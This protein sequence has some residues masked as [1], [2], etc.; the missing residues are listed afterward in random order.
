MKILEASRYSWK[1]S[2]KYLFILI[3]LTAIFFFLYVYTSNRRIF[4][5]VVKKRKYVFFDL[6]ANNGDSMVKFFYDRS[7]DHIQGIFYIYMNF[8]VYF[9]IIK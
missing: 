6:G 3:L 5:N 8:Y 4:E 1:H 7:F 2:W 9:F